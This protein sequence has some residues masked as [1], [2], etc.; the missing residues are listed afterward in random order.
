MLPWL[1]QMQ[2]DY[3]RALTASGRPREIERASEFLEAA[4]A[5]YRAVGMDAYTSR[6]A[7]P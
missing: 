4:R 1:A 2:E 6:S 7:R 3:A 5:T